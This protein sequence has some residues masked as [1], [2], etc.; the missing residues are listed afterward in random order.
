MFFMKQRLCEI[1]TCHH[2]NPPSGMCVQLTETRASKVPTACVS[3]DLKLDFHA[4]KN[5]SK[6]GIKHPDFVKM[7][8]MP[9]FA[10]KAV[11]ELWQTQA[12]N[13]IHIVLMDHR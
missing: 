10:V 13:V 11:M 1:Q 7:A 5:L 12:A 3:D 9:V 2:D 6:S 4:P 8:L